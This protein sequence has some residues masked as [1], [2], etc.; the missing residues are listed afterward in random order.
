MADSRL[1]AVVDT[2]ATSRFTA[3][4]LG[5]AIDPTTGQLAPCA[6]I[7]LS[8][9]YD[10]PGAGH[11]H[12]VY[13]DNV[14]CIAY[15]ARNRNELADKIRP[16]HVMLSSASPDILV[17][18]IER[19]EPHDAHLVAQTSSN[20]TID[21]AYSLW[22]GRAFVYRRGETVKL[23]QVTMTAPYGR[24]NQCFFYLSRYAALF[25]PRSMWFLEFG[26]LPFPFPFNDPV[27]K[28]VRVLYNRYGHVDD[29]GVSQGAYESL[30]TA[31]VVPATNRD[32]AVLDARE[33][34]LD[35]EAYQAP[36]RAIAAR[37]F[38]FPTRRSGRR[39]VVTPRAPSTRMRRMPKRLTYT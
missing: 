37:I 39:V 29:C 35:D 7:T 24:M 32:V 5:A 23:N 22:Q 20:D 30:N 18:H 8:V 25:A 27:N 2:T 33:A 34:A 9:P 28:R 12:G 31:R 38:Q 1:A 21:V 3:Y 10:K 17:T 6:L 19:F 4:K 26:N 14:R 11:E 16:S 13:Y 15:T 36:Y